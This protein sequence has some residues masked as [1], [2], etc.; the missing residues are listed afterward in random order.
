M[1][2]PRASIILPAF[3]EEAALPI[4]L[5]AMSALLENGYEIVV[6]DDGS[7]DSTAEIASNVPGVRVVR[8]P[9]NR[10]KGAAMASGAAAASAERL[11][12][13]D[14]DAT[15][16]ASAIPTLV[17]MLDQHD[18]VRGERPLDSE[19][20]PALNRAG[21]R[22]FNRLLGSF[23]RL[24]G[25]DFLSGM[26]AMHRRA[27]E[28]LRLESAG[29]DIEVEIGVKA[30]QRGLSVGTVDIDYH[31]RVGEKKLRPL[32]DGLRILT[33]TAGMAILYSPTITFVV[34]GLAIMAL[35]LIGAIALAGGPV[36]V[37]SIGLSINSFVLAMLGFV[38]GFQLV[39]LGVAATLYRIETGMPPKRWLLAMAHRPVRLGAALGGMLVAVIASG[40]L[41]WLVVSWV[42]GGAGEFLQTDELV[43]AAALLVVGLQ[44]LSAGLFLSIFSGRLAARRD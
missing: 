37:G 7:A 13:V 42:S 24:E 17:T 2:G 43:A 16:P 20:I 19:N 35:G 32:R 27:F 33:R 23:H 3:N 28:A 9:V 11:V 18:I 22:M 31:P 41:L 4:V 15:Y 30:R 21:N 26:Y 38:A 8:H 36:F 14:A 44:L 6:V 5:D 29:F 40:W 34:P 25:N 1:T 39:V 10:G 12:F